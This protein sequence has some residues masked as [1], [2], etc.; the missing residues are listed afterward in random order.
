MRFLVLILLV[1]LWVSMTA[2]AQKTTVFKDTFETHALWSTLS[3][4]V[5]QTGT[6]W[7]EN[8]SGTNYIQ[9][10]FVRN[11]LQGLVVYRDASVYPALTAQGLLGAGNE[12]TGDGTPYYFTF[13]WYQERG[14]IDRP[15][16]FADFGIYS[17]IAGVYVGADNAYRVW[18][19]SQGGYVGT[20]VSASAGVWDKIE[21]ILYPYDMGGSAIV[22]SY[23][24]YLIRAGK[25]TAMAHNIVSKSRVLDGQNNAQMTFYNDP[26]SGSATY[27]SVYYDDVYIIRDYIPV[28]G[29]AEHSVPVGDL[30]ADC[31]VDFTDFAILAQYWME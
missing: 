26:P 15:L 29:D 8:G 4:T 11:G 5:P 25:R 19:E 16:V 24:V 22:C 28:C 21:M 13:S 12:V 6:V 3:A 30:N 27:T 2:T 18:D 20:G 23:D 14:G 7:Q 17:G 31:R 10:N 9:S 1:T